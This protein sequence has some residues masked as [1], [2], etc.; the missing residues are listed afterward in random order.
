[1]DSRAQM[2]ATVS[3]VSTAEWLS[4]PV[5][6]PLFMSPCRETTSGGKPSKVLSAQGCTVGA[7]FA[8][9]HQAQPAARVSTGNERLRIASRLG[10][11]GAGSHLEIRSL[12]PVCCENR[13]EPT[14]KSRTH[15]PITQPTAKCVCRSSA[16]RTD[17]K[18]SQRSRGPTASRTLYF[19]ILPLLHLMHGRNGPR[20]STQPRVRSSGSSS[21]SY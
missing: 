19:A 10:V 5:A 4:A 16:V 13:H 3:R 15:C 2:P 7:F 14:C 21:S 20:C 9:I 18:K 12:A 6:D 17:M 8:N 11:T 1:M